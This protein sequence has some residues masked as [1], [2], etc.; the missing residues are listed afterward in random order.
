MQKLSFHGLLQRWAPSCSSDHKGVNITPELKN[1]LLEIHNK[2]RQQQAA[3]ETPNYEPAARMGTL[4]WDEGLAE[5]AGYNVRLCKY[6]HDPCRNTGEIKKYCRLVC[7][8][9][10]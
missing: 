7:I 3:G 5:M 8:K 2:Q 10:I 9:L 1:R 4:V 6:D